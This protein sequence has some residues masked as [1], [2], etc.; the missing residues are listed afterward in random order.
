MNLH[1]VKMISRI[2]FVLLVLETSRSF[3]EAESFEYSVD[4]FKGSRS[5]WYDFSPYEH[6]RQRR[7]A[8]TA[9]AP[10]STT[11]SITP[12]SPTNNTD[13]NR[14]TNND[15]PTVVPEQKLLGV[16]GSGILHVN[17]TNLPKVSDP[18]SATDDTTNIFKETPEIIKAE[19]H[20]ANLTYDDHNFY[21]SSFIGN[22]T[23][24]QEYWTN[25]SKT[26]AEPHEIL[27]NSHRRASTIKLGFD[28]PFYGHGV[29]NITVATGGFLYLGDLVHNWLAATQYIAPLMANF[30]TTISNDSVVKMYDDGEKFTVFWE[31]A[32]LQEAPDKKFTFA[33]TL[34]KNGDI[35]F[36]YKDVPIPVQ[37][38]KDEEHPVKVGI[39]DAYLKDKIIFYVRRKTIYEYHRVSFKY[40]EITNNTVL[41]LTALPTC[42]QYNNCMSCVNH[43]TSFDCTWCEALQK[44]SSGTDRNKQDWLLR[45][46]DKVTISKEASCP[47]GVDAPAGANTAYHTDSQPPRDAEVHTLNTEVVKKAES[48]LTAPISKPEQSSPVG[49]VV[50]A[51][52]VITLI[53]C[54]AGWLLYAFKNP[55]SR[56][57]Q[58]LIRYRPSQWGWRRGE[59]RYT[60][61][62][63]H[64]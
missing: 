55:L 6:E 15:K 27:S 30:D 19:Q 14:T 53:C 20:L 37:S 31:N 43:D 17:V 46:C 52:V 10:E 39:S 32:T 21:K 8:P 58:I 45:N 1:A 13:S 5:N 42:L 38:I 57:G 2:T 25:I 16:N 47:A 64:M 63:I 60:A 51:F 54:F 22:L 26:K 9:V 44:C 61:A 41:R 4:T 29:R 33:V 24:F 62:T 11:A 18:I 59:A 49:G 28:F 12:P 36:A 40:H 3:V 34:Y 48:P 7:Q 23:Y 56:S 50:T 35:V